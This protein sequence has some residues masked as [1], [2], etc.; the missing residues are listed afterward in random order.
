MEEI[1]LQVCIPSYIRVLG[2]QMFILIISILLLLSIRIDLFNNPMNQ[3]FKIGPQSYYWL[4]RLDA[5]GVEEDI[6]S[7]VVAI[8]ASSSPV[9]IMI[10]SIYIPIPICIRLILR[11]TIQI[12]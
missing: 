8:F 3:T 10:Y 7:G 4:F 2:I 5:A 12:R 6:F 9:V 1:H 11:Y